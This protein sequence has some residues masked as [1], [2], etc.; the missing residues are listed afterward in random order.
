MDLSDNL[1]DFASLEPH[2]SVTDVT[3]GP[4][5]VFFNEVDFLANVNSEVVINYTLGGSANNYRWFKDDVELTG[6]TGPTLTL[7]S[8][9]FV[10]EGLYRAEVTNSLVPGVTLTTAIFILKVSSLER[11]QIALTNI[12]NATGGTE[13]TD[14]TNSAGS[15]YIH[16]VRCHCRKQQGNTLGVTCQ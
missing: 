4:Q 1:I 5:K 9:Q 11:D 15:G 8:V 16:L 14:N 2:V 13:W 10:N 12:F 3:L 6:E 7:S